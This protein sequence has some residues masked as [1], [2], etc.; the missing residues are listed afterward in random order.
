MNEAEETITIDS[1][2][3]YRSSGSSPLH[4]RASAGTDLRI[5]ELETENSRL[6]RLVVELLFRNEQLRKE[7][8]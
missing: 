1:T 2:R 8:D 3:D 4:H 5:M 7:R 6:Q